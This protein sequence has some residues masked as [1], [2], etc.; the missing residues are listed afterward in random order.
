M[1]QS[2]VLDAKESINLLKDSYGRDAIQQIIDDGNIAWNDTQRHRINFQRYF[3]KRFGI[4][5]TITTWPWRNAAN[6]FIPV[7]DKTIRRSKP[8]FIRLVESVNPRVTLK[9]NL[10]GDDLGFVRAIERKFDD[11]LLDKVQIVEKVALGVDKMLERGYFLGK[12][13]QEFTPKEVEE[14]MYMDRLPDSWKEFLANPELSDDELGYAIANRFEMDVNDNEAI[15]QIRDA[16]AQFRSGQKII[17]FKRT[18]DQTDYPSLYIRDPIKVTVPYDTQDIRY[19]RLVRDRLT[20]IDRDIQ[21]NGESG[22]WDKENVYE[23]LNRIGSSASRRDRIK[24]SGSKEEEYVEVLENIKD[25]VYPT[26]H[27]PDIDEYYFYFK[28]PG[29]ILATPSVLTI[30]SDNTDL[31]LRFIKYPYVDEYGNPDVWPFSQVCFEIVSERYHAQRGIPQMLDSLQIEITNNHNAKQ[32]HMTISTSLNIKAKRNSNI[33]TNYI[34]GQPVWVNRMDDVEELN[35]QSKD[36]SFD[37]EEQILKEWVE[38]Y[39]GNV[40]DALK[41]QGSLTEPRTQEEIQ[42]LG[43]IE[44]NIVYGDLVIFQ[45][46]MN[47]IY[48]QLWN[49]WLQYGPETL[50]IQ[51]ADGSASTIE[52][53]EIRRRFRLKPTGN[54]GNSSISKRKKDAL[55]RLALYKDDPYINQY[56][57][58]RQALELDDERVAEVLLLTGEQVSQNH[59]DN[60]VKSIQMINQ[61]YTVVP[62]IS[63]DNTTYVKT[64][65][66]YLTDPVKK[67]NFH[68]DRLPELLNYRQAHLLALDRKNRATTRNG[69]LQQ[70]VANVAKGIYG[71]QARGAVSADKLT[72]EG[73]LNG[74]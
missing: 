9:S 69:R 63:D 42:K 5:P 37:N 49:R 51:K 24:Y 55:V 18:I 29:D 13:V 28:W 59:I 31:P 20:M 58:R 57:L 40:D 70:E 8:R 45:I 62:K 52:K 60:A 4:R 38:S 66:D 15:R 22:L 11:I 19:S 27:L 17:R 16:I 71:R 39:I 68:Q 23:L 43:D 56:E 6:L 34:P 35:V 48:Q 30:N 73:V 67:R 36:V 50:S 46:G 64:I 74:A 53:E 25:G 32:N 41:S 54:I 7:I 33:S 44:D 14:V 26:G 21:S 47:K 3:K 2:K 61:G 10:V 65:D 72:K 12:V 1:S